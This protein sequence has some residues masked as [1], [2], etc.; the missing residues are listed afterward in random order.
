MKHQ[1][2]TILIA[3]LCVNLANSQSTSRYYDHDNNWGFG[4]GLNIV[5]DSGTGFS[6]LFNISDNWN[7]GTPAVL[8]ATYYLNNKFSLSSS[9][10]FNK[11]KEGKVID[12]GSVLS[13]SEARY[14]AVDFSVNY[15]FRDLFN[16]NAFAPYVFV[17]AGYTKISEYETNI[18]S[19]IIPDQ[20]RMTANI[21]LGVNYWLSE[22]W[23]LNMNVADK[24]GL[25]DD[26]TNQFQY[27]FG[28]NYLFAT[29]NLFRG[30]GY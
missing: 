24:F 10:S 5:D 25:A 21:G 8:S 30:V 12:G 18:S 28:I 4:I 7:F 20:G 1:I 13:G 23:G 14:F 15:S 3:I 17:G 9:F 22:N 29:S 19:G 11:Y 26:A 6:E 27:G 16:T 2:I